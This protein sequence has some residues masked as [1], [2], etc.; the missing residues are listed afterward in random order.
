MSDKKYLLT[1]DECN[2]FKDLHT[3]GAV[4]SFMNEHEYHERTCKRIVK[5]TKAGGWPKEV[6][7]KCGAGIGDDRYVYCWRC[8]A[9]VVEQ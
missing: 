1:M 3:V 5:G 4:R 9:K 6:C 7:S 8:G 2:I